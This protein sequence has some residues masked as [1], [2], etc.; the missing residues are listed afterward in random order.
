MCYKRAPIVIAVRREHGT[1]ESLDIKLF[2]G[3]YL[4]TIKREIGKLDD[5]ET[6]LLMMIII[7]WWGKDWGRC[8]L[9]EY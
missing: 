8:I 6:V 5:W 7:M 3:V 2:Y 1:T 9:T 4:L